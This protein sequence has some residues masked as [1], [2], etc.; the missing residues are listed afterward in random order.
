[1]KVWFDADNAPHVLVIKPIAEEL[2]RQGH[3]VF[4]T[5]RNRASTCD[6]LDMYGLAYTTVGGRYPRG[7]FGKIA[8]TLGRAMKLAAVCRKEHSDVSFGHGSR[9]LPLASWLIGVPSVTMYD[10]EWVNPAIFNRFC[11]KIL[12]PEVIDDERC[13]EAGIRLDKVIRFPGF[14]ENLYLDGIEP[15]PSIGEELGLKP[16]NMHVLIRPPATTAHYHNPEAE[17]ILAA[18]LGRL[19]SR[20][21]VQIVWIP[22]DPDPYSFANKKHHAEVII[23]E[24]TFPGPQLILSCDLVIGGGG[25]MTREAAILGVPAISFFRGRAG[26]VDTSLKDMSR[27]LIIR[28]T[29]EL[30]IALSTINSRKKAAPL[31]SVDSM[32]TIQ[33]VI[34][35]TGETS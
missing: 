3:E 10:Y 22:R 8:G 29:R 2:S 5:A 11:R 18:L 27:L 24:K 26:S 25:T 16:D 12:L 1:M 33:N 15:D 14:K 35:D 7:I 13:H 19:L 17:V 21:D 9:A 30:D 31:N 4:V 23:P 28:D 34:I 32:K 6:L 20:K